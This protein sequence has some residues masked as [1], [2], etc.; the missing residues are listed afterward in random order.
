MFTPLPRAE[1]RAKP[2]VAEEE[3]AGGRLGT[4]TSGRHSGP[5]GRGGSLPFAFTGPGTAA[6]SA[7]NGVCHSK[8]RITPH[9]GIPAEKGPPRNRGSFPP[10]AYGGLC[11]PE[12]GVPSRPRASRN[13]AIRASARLRRA[14]PAGGRRSKPSPRLFAAGHARSTGRRSK[15]SPRF[16]AVGD[17]R[18]R[19]ASRSVPCA[20]SGQFG[21][22]GARGI[23]K[24]PS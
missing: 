13:S 16:F 11:R 8:S 20:R 12:A 5:Q 6:R 15:P 18:S 1:R 9:A 24:K 22:P 14:V 3:K 7:A 23:R 2:H 10:P 19:C 17:A 4:P 21:S